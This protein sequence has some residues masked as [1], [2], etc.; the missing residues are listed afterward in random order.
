M[1]RNPD[2]V[3]APDVAFVRADRIPK[4]SDGSGFFNGPPDLAVEIL[5]PNDRFAGVI[6]KVNEYLQ[7]GTLEVWLI[8]PRQHAITLHT[9]NTQPR[10]FNESDSLN[11]SLALPGFSEAVAA[12]FA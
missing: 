12:F 11:G 1:S 4:D 5:S 8:D 10:V 6:E 9:A 3:R 2:T 7:A